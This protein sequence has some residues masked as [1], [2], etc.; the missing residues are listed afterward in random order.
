MRGTI[1]LHY[2]RKAV[3]AAEVKESNGNLKHQ[4]GKKENNYQ[5]TDPD[6]Q[7]CKIEKMGNRDKQGLGEKF[8]VQ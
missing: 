6:F 5:K 3:S 7:C 4:K 1:L 2:M 8:T